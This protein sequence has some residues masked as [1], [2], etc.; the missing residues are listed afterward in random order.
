MKIEGIVSVWGT[1]AAQAVLRRWEARFR[2]DNPGFHVVYHMTGS[3]IGMAG[4]YTGFAD[5]AVLG[6]ECTDVES[7]AF[8]WIFRYPPS[9]VQIMTG[10]LEQAGQSPALIAYVHRDN[11]LARLTLLQ[12]GAV[13]GHEHPGGAMQN[14]RSWGALG[15]VGE[16]LDLPINLYADDAESG[17]G[18]FFRR[19]VLNGSA[20]MN[21]DALREFS[22][23]DAPTKILAAVAADRA[24]LAVTAGGGKLIPPLVKAVPLGREGSE[25]VAA[26]RDSLIS[27]RYPLTRAVHVYF[28]RSPKLTLDVRA[29]GFLRYI[30][31]DEAQR[32]IV[33]QGDY[34]PLSPQMAD[35]QLQLL[36]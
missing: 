15:L 2:R 23:H 8:E 12:L 1:Q 14:I 4:L 25:F 19:V 22:G 36:G 9:Q 31:S 10:S 33:D 30:L 11:P 34:L 32:E 5:L 24:G 21:W 7:K 35:R 18:Q 6:R 3:D 29:K 28:K 13:F 17:T 26:S 20:R 16:W 27:R